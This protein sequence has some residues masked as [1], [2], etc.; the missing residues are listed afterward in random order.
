M[1][2]NPSARESNNDSIIRSFVDTFASRN[3]DLLAPFFTDDIVFENYGDPVIHG[4]P[5]LVKMWAGVFANFVEVK[6]ETVNQA[7][8]GDVVIAEQVHGL[9]LRAGR[10]A[11]IKNLAVYE[12]RDGKIAA[13][14]DYTNP[15][16]ARALFSD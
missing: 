3:A 5:A 4:R 16:K 15:Q 9:G 12:M 11:P 2:D 7:V 13:W 6:F 1:S 10:L 14:R 8:E